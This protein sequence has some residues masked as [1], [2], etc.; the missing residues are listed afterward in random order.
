MIRLLSAGHTH[1]H[2]YGLSFLFES[3]KILQKIE[4]EKMLR[5]AIAMKM[6]VEAIENELKE[7]KKITPKDLNKK[8]G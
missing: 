2:E 1:A 3:F 7:E 5:I 6:S 8:I 4:K